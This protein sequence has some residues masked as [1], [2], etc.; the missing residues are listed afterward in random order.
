MLP[1][2][3]FLPW[4]RLRQRRSARR[5]ACA[6]LL[7]AL[8]IAASGI[9]WQGQAALRFHRAA[10]WQH[11]DGEIAAALDGAKKPLQLRQQQW[12]QAQA[13]ASRQQNTRLWRDTLLALAER[14][15]PQAWLTELRWQQERLTLSGLAGSFSAL[16][17][18]E[19]RLQG[20]VGFALQP[21]GAMARDTQGRWRFHYQLNREHN[22][23]LQP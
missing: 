2:V 9:A 3:N 22:D 21:A 17:E 12:R 19:L 23:G 11:S 13:R 6:F 16:R 14:L 5:W 10:L 7:T 15:P 1:V 18:M 20:V 8:V 4:R